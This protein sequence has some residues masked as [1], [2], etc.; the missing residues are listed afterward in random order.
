LPLRARL[1][2]ENGQ[3]PQRN[4]RETTQT[5]GADLQEAHYCTRPFAFHKILL[6]D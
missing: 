3:S 6:G 2:G 1:G 4:Q 5:S